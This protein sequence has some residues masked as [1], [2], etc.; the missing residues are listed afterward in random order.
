MELHDI[1]FSQHFGTVMGLGIRLVEDMVGMGKCIYGD[2]PVKHY[3]CLWIR[4]KLQ[5]R[6]R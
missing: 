3:N 5:N 6:I 2:L 4:F 1:T